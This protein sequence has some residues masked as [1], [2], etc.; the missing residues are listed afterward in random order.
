MKKIFFIGLLF[1][2]CFACAHTKSETVTR[3]II[4]QEIKKT[5]KHNLRNNSMQDVKE[6]VEKIKN[7]DLPEIKNKK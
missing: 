6:S 7:L 4:K 2:L 3:K 5:E 1:C